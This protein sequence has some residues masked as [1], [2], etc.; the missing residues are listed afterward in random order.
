MSDNELV[1]CPCAEQ[2]VPRRCALCGTPNAERTKLVPAAFVVEYNLL[3]IRLGDNSK[4]RVVKKLLERHGM[5]VP[6]GLKEA[7]NFEAYLEDLLNKS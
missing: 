6:K 4:E 3:G 2:I 1:P 7:A 5:Y